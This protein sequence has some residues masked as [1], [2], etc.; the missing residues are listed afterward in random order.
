MEIEAS[1][2]LSVLS[3]ASDAFPN[4]RIQLHKDLAGHDR[5][6]EVQV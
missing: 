2:G 3:L 6:L 4:A 5:L 1:E